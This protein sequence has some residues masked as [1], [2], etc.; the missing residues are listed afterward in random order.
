MRESS[1]SLKWYLTE[2]LGEKGRRAYKD[3]EVE[4]TRPKRQQESADCNMPEGKERRCPGQDGG[5][6]TEKREGPDY[7]GL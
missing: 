4:H 1:L 6:K 7:V 2:D 5:R 3:L